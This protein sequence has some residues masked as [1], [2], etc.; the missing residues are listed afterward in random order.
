MMKTTNLYTYSGRISYPDAAPSLFDVAISLS[1]EG[2]YSGNGI[3]W[4][5]VALHT[6]VVCDML[7]ETI[8]IHGLM[9][10]APESVTGD[11]PKPVKTKEIEEFEEHLLVMLYKSFGIPFPDIE[12]RAAVK[13]VD[14]QVLHGEVYTVGTQAL[15]D[16]YPRCPEAE[17]HVLRYVD[18][19]SYNDCLDAGGRVPIEFVRR[20]RLYLER[21]WTYRI[22]ITEPDPDA[23]I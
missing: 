4:W 7:P 8:Q 13:A 21:M 11:V 14:K 16:L 2:R 9:H 1:R 15:Q 23:A 6:F 18:K 20:F 3:R 19:Y 17:E 10:D 22:G 12:T 5:P